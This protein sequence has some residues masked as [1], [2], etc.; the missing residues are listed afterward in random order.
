MG[1]PSIPEGPRTVPDR[2]RS[3]AGH[4]GRLS[5][6]RFLE[7][8]LYDPDAGFYQAERPR[9]GP[10]GDFYTAAHV[11][12][13]FG[14]TI[15]ARIWAEF[16]RRGRPYG[17]RVVEMGPGD[18][19]LAS[20]IASALSARLTPGEEV[21]Y[22]LVDRA[23]RM[24]DRALDRIARDGPMN[25]IRWRSAPSL[26]GDGVFAG[27]VLANEFLDALPFRRLVWRGG[28]WHE[29]LVD[30][31]SEPFSWAEGPMARGVPSP[32]LPPGAR[33]GAILEV[34]LQAEAFLREVG[35]HLR[36]GAAL[37]LDY[38]ADEE[39]L[40]QGHSAGTLTGFR[41][42]RAVPYPLES[43]GEVDLSAFVNFTRVRS[44]ARAS[45]LTEVGYRSQADTLG[46]WGFS[47]LLEAE[48]AATGDPE[49]RVKTQL[50]A[51]NLLFGFGNFQ[52]LELAT[53]A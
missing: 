30:L 16:V 36:S 34:G 47:E 43:P 21:E 38:G 35:D 25:G 23:A 9:L 10:E 4:G 26:S 17:F 8:A 32:A 41:R 15:A 2:L 13:L 20:Q 51:K 18:G 11:H 52:V 28:S 3:A 45:G 12:P 19:A 7:I 6:D 39:V 37:F 48:L 24:L 44:S 40:I 49:A 1:T 46:A 50:A 29:L 53:R 5:F 42:H 14:R 22:L 31:S 27:V 33:E